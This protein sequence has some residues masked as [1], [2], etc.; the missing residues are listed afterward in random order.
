MS[1]NLKPLGA[2]PG[3]SIEPAGLDLAGEGRGTLHC[4]RSAAGFRAEGEVQVRN[5]RAAGPWGSLSE[6]Q[7]RLTI[8]GTWDPK[9]QQGYVDAATLSGEAVAA[10]AQKVVL[11]RAAAGPWQLCGGRLVVGP[12]LR[13]GI[14]RKGPA[15]GEAAAPG[16][17]FPQLVLNPAIGQGLLKFIA[18]VLAE[19]SGAR[20]NLLGRVGR[21]SRPVG[22][23]Y[24]RRDRRTA[25]AS[26][27]WRRP[28]A[29][30]S[31]SS[32]RS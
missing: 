20:G 27:R 14:A 29:R 1:F 23:A 21:L 12:K 5:L 24:R 25:A 6:P 10:E 32:P 19:A 11:A 26:S 18:P 7:A 3:R 28:P 15:N 8:S 2:G 31:A 4:G 17:S 9:L 22:P 16:A 30:W 13:I